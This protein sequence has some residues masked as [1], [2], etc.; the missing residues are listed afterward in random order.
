M[1]RISLVT[2]SLVLAFFPP[3]FCRDPL[4]QPF[5]H[6]S[7]WNRPIGSGA[8]Y[9]HAR[10]QN[11][12]ERGMTVDEDILI[13]RPEAPMTE[14]YYNGAGWDRNRS[15][16]PREGRLIFSAPIPADFV[17]SP[18]TWDGLTPNSGLAVLMPDGRTIKQTQPFARCTAGEPATTLYSFPDIDLYGDG[19]RG[20]H[21]GSGLS[22]YGGTLRLGELLP[23]AGPIRHV[24]KVNIYGAR[25]LFYNEETKG[26]RWPAVTADGY[27][28]REYGKSGDPVKACRMGALLALPATMDLDRMG[29]ETEPGRILAQAFQDYGA[30]LVD[31]TAWDVYA[32]V[33]EWSPDGRVTEEFK[34]AWGFEMTPAG[35]NNAW[36]RDMDRIFTNLHVVDNNG[37]NSVGGGGSPLAPPAA[38]LLEPG[39][40]RPRNR[41]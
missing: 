35:R 6:Q 17:V 26:Y 32:I 1:S 9:V 25:N 36:S 28:A 18:A 29:F 31:D 30:Y 33:T 2:W 22:A 27:A 21:G 4:K 15:R 8:V 37:P 40:P 11:S 14:I 7:I 38:P 5:H 13:L 19:I 20:A 12:T 39:R 24:L 23:G 3:V 10:I 16:C 41:R 34:A